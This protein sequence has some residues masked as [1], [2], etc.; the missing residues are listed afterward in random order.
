MRR[1]LRSAGVLAFFASALG[2]FMGLGVFFAILI[3]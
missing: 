2:L 3:R 1:S